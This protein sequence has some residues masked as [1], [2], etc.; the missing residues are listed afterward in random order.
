[1]T[2]FGWHFQFFGRRPLRFLHWCSL[3]SPHIPN[4]LIARSCKSCIGLENEE[5]KWPKTGNV[6]LAKFACFNTMCVDCHFQ[7]AG[8]SKVLVRAKILACAFASRARFKTRACR[9]WRAFICTS[10]AV[11]FP[12]WGNLNKHYNEHFIVYVASF[13]KYQPLFRGI[14]DAW[15]W[16]RNKCVNG[17]NAF[18]IQ[19]Q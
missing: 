17:E 13:T 2:A 15:K 14:H 12:L 11:H 19:W 18:I 3:F 9:A 1:M 6:I 8:L 7:I 16:P 5:R 4:Y 10:H